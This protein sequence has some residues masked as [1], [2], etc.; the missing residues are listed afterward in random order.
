M[1]FNVGKVTNFEAKNIHALH[2]LNRSL[3]VESAMEKH[4]DVQLMLTAA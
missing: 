4:L 1:R 3:L 2:T